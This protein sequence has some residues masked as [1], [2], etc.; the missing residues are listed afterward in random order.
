MHDNAN[1]LC[2][3]IYNGTPYYFFKNLQRDIIAITNSDGNVV[4]KYSYDVW[5]VPT[6]TSDTSGCDIATVNPFRYR[7]Y[8]YDAESGLYYVQSRYYD[9]SIGRFI[10]T[11]FPEMAS[12]S[13]LINNHI[14]SHLFAYCYNNPVIHYDPTGMLAPVVIGGITVTAAQALAVFS[15]L[16]LSAAYIFNI[17]GFRTVVNDAI[18]WAIQGLVLSA[19]AIQERFSLKSQVA[20]RIV[21]FVAIYALDTA[22]TLTNIAKK[23]KNKE[24]VEAAE[25]MKKELLKRKFSGY[26]IEIYFPTARNG[27]VVSDRTN[28]EA[29]SDTGRHR[30]V[31]FA[32][33]VYCN[34][35][36]EGLAE[37]TWLSKFHAAYEKDRK[38]YKYYF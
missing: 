25:A 37:P 26:I 17:G 22:G 14:G 19:S 24:C 15:V 2:G 3:I 13:L 29:I 27:L 10:N 23:H 35:Y 28:N 34:V 9:P 36:P 18:S 12:I 7:G 31:G 5:G 11:D 21:V 30:G 33:K 4:A 20:K 38:V 1:G 8:Y 16:A 6:I 32:E